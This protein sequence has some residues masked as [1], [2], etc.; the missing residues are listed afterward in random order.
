MFR[1]VTGIEFAEG[2]VIPWY[3]GRCYYEP[4]S[5]FV[6]L[7]PVPLNFL[8]GWGYE[9]WWR[10]RRGPD[11]I[12]Q[13]LQQARSHGFREGMKAGQKSAVYAVRTAIRFGNMDGIHDMI[14]SI[15][16]SA[17]SK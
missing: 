8:I 6:I 16:S 12:E 10:M 5:D 9:A 15:D 3:L 2:Y 14:R 4:S 13:R 17:A 7:A 11:G 1:T